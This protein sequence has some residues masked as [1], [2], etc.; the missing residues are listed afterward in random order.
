MS[1]GIHTEEGGHPTPK[2]YVIIAAILAVITAVEV[3]VVYFNLATALLITILIIMS[4][5]KFTMVAMYFMHLKFD[6]KL[7]SYMFVG[8]MVLTLGVILALMILFNAA[9]S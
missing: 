8:G 9:G 4:A 2:K 3:A 1:T 7:F 6:N 5:V